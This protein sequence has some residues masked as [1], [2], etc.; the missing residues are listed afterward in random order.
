MRREELR[1]DEPES[2]EDRRDRI[3]AMVEPEQRTWDLSPND[4]TAIRWMSEINA[5]LLQLVRDM[6]DSGNAANWWLEQAGKVLANA[7]GTDRESA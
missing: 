1:K 3:R 2:A 7:D 4:V 6:H 5:E